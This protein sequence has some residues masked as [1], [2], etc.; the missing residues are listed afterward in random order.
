MKNG[1]FAEMMNSVCLMV[2]ALRRHQDDGGTTGIDGAFIDELDGLRQQAE[3]L[4]Y[5]QEDLKA[6]TKMKTAELEKVLSLLGRK[7]AEAHKR[8]KLDYPLTSWKEFGIRDKR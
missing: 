1:S 4:N 6:Q 5:E 2:A 7:Q 3:H 8:V